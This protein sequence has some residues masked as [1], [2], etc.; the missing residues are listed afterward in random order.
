MNAYTDEEVNA[1][2][3]VAYAMIGHAVNDSAITREDA[4]SMGC[5]LLAILTG[6]ESAERITSL[7]ELM[8]TL[9][10]SLR[11]AWQ[12]SYFESKEDKP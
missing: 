5:Q 10:P 7:A 11:D 1:L 6:M 4:W 3:A 2:Q 9:P 8:A 12:E